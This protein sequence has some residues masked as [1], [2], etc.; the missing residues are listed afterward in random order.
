MTENPVPE[1]TPE[2]IS[3]YEI[4]GE[5][6]R[7]GMATVYLAWDPNFDRE[8]A[9]KVLPRELLHDPSFRTRFQREARTIAALEH[10]A[11]VPVYDFGEQDGV[12]FLVMRHMSGGSLVSRIRA[13]PIP[14]AEAAK[15]LLRIG[16]A[17]DA[18]HA[19]GIVHRDLKPANILFDSYG[20]AYLGDFGI[21]Q[22][23]GHSGT[24]TGPMVLGTP[25][26]MSPEQIRGEKKVD[27]RS[28][29]YALGIVMF[30]MLT[31]KA[32]FEADSPVK[33]MMMHLSTPPP[34][35]PETAIHLPAGA[36]DIISRALAKEPDERYQ[37]A[38]DF[39]RDFQDL[40]TGQR[41]ALLG[42]PP[43]MVEHGAETVDLPLAPGKPRPFITGYTDE[44]RRKPRRWPWIAALG[45]VAALAACLC[46]GAGG[47]GTLLAVP[48]IREWLFSVPTR[49]PVPP[50]QTPTVTETVPV[51]ETPAPVVTPETPSPTVPQY[52]PGEPFLLSD[53]SGNSSKPFL[54]IDGDGFIHAF[55]LDETD[56]PH[57]QLI[58]R[59]LSPEGVWSDPDCAS[60]LAGEPRFVYQY[61]GAVQPGVKAC[62]AFRHLEG[63][64]YILSDVCYRGRGP[65]E[66]HQTEIGGS[67]LEF[68]VSF[69]PSGV[70]IAA[71]AGVQAIRIGEQ[72]I[73]DNSLY[74]YSPA[75][76]VDA[77]G[78][79]HLLWIR[80]TDPAALIYRYS[81]DRGSTWTNPAVLLEDVNI[82]NDV[83]LYA[84]RDGSLIMAVKGWGT[85]IMRWDGSW[86]EPFPL[87]EDFIAYS[88]AF[89]EDIGAAVSIVSVGWNDGDDGVW[90]FNED[91]ESGGWS[92]PEPVLAMEDS[93]SLGVAAVF[94]LEREVCVMYGIPG[95][96]SIRG[97]FYFVAK[98]L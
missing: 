19:K 39:G 90:M 71:F 16:S 87:S 47:G 14:P 91:D 29:I 26:Y 98:D 70:L 27:G 37:K 74:M 97:D 50:T 15:I 62:A 44:L 28:D 95:E 10:P 78:G 80:H 85:R 41:R 53:G 79:Y 3:R 20:E 1:P 75:F 17:L 18:A 40:T 86:S 55:W 23:S 22:L 42:V 61:Q 77:D 25:A 43:G 60:C 2:K 59:S 93:N 46:L 67:E 13:G 35:V 82:S 65:G 30:E 4:R 69:D 33:M 5:I 72:T 96:D 45:A 32:P 48:N 51:V 9:I 63:S 88:Y 57:G 73:S 31:G 34:R 38:A 94:G 84:V 54:A 24:L 36:N 68:L 89:L 21:A 83:L 12:P 11:I 56:S 58:H 64:D 7:G 81:G 8:V 6:G 52:T 76:A 49:T 66:L 92:A